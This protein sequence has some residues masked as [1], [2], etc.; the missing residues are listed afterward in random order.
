MRPRREHRTRHTLS[1]K[2]Q[3]PYR[4]RVAMQFWLARPSAG[5]L[6]S[7]NAEGMPKPHATT[8]QRTT[9][10]HGIRVRLRRCLFRGPHGFGWALNQVFVERFWQNVTYDEVQRHDDAV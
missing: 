10:R 9:V 6:G 5:I 3:F 8:D 2:Q 1:I 7:M 4:I